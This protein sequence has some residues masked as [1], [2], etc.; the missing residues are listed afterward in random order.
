MN[1]VD[2]AVA[3]SEAGE[4]GGQVSAYVFG[5]VTFGILGL[6]LIITMMIKVDR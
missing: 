3:A 6:L 2:A 5:L 1:W 4:Q